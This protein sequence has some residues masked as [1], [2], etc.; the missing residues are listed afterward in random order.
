MM[1]MG[2]TMDNFLLRSFNDGKQTYFVT[3]D[4]LQD[5]MKALENPEEISLGF[6]TLKDI[7]DKQSVI[8]AVYG[9]I[10]ED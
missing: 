9:D 6:E 3:L 1:I 7:E 2:M 4:Q 5:L 10:V 8:N